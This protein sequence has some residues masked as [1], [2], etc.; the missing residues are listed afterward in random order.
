METYFVGWGTLALIN[1]ALANIDERGAL[2]YFLA[3]IFFGPVVTLILAATRPVEG[4]GLQQSDIW[5][6]GVARP[7]PVNRSRIPRI[8]S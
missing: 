6:G 3:S 5:R 1:A 7:R 8:G 4:H 2:K